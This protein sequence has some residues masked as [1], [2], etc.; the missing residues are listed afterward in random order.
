MQP[1]KVGDEFR[2][3]IICIDSYI[4]GIPDGRFFNPQYQVPVPFH[5]LTQFLRQMENLL[6]ELRFPQSFAEL[7]TFG[8]AALQKPC[9]ESVD[10]APEGRLGTFSIKVIF[11]QNASWQ[12]SV[13]WMNQGREESFRSALELIFLLDSAL[14]TA[15]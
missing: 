1:K 8:T 12:G 9:T 2:T 3:T 11:R 5:S 7:R 14:N 13:L 6:N 4:N 15:G 10:T